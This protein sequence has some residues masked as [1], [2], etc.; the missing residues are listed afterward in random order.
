MERLVEELDVDEFHRLQSVVYRVA[1]AISATVPTERVYV[2]SLG[3]QQGNAHVHWHVASLPTGIP[4]EKQQFH[5]V[6]AENGVLAVTD[7]EQEALAA[8]VRR[9]M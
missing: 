1:R 3:S 7:A 4:Y 9:N 6:M 5:S 2:M 8:A